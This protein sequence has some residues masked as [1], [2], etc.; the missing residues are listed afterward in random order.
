MNRTVTRLTALILAAMLSLSLFACESDEDDTPAAET[1]A[2]TTDGEAYHA[3]ASASDEGTK[4]DDEPFEVP[5]V[6]QPDLDKAGFGDVIVFGSYEQDG[7]KS[8]GPEPLE[9]IVVHREGDRVLVV[10]R[11]SI[12]ESYMNHTMWS[13]TTW[14]K[15]DLR[16]TLNGM[17]MTAAFEKSEAEMIAETEVETDG[18]T[19][20][21]RI[22]LLSREEVDKFLAMDHTTDYLLLCERAYSTPKSDEDR[23]VRWW[24]RSV[25]DNN[26]RMYVVGK[27]GDYEPN[28]PF[29]SDAGVRPAMWLNVNR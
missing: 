4:K 7:D 8:N 12:Y 17:F 13:G 25:Y 26:N 23:Y 22:F 6:T 19:T 27:K 29:N 24:L 18:K 3:G 21:D 28:Y 2:V 20:K 1:T 9:W 5:V 16:K 10:S 15:C 11:Y 14:E